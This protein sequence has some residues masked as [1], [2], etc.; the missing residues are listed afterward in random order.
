MHPHLIDR[1]H[2][3]CGSM[4]TLEFGTWLLDHMKER[5]VRKDIC[6]KYHEIYKWPMFKKKFT[7][8]PHME[9]NLLCK[10]IVH[11]I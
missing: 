11:G 10:A 2:I 3:T 7:N 5:D 8:S 4:F 9:M 6:F 1:N